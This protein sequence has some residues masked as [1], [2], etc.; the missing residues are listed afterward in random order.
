MFVL[1][2][3]ASAPVVPLG[4]D[5][6]QRVIGAERS[7]C[8]V[9]PVPHDQRA[10][11]LRGLVPEREILSPEDFLDGELR[12]RICNSDFQ[13]IPLYTI[14]RAANCRTAPP[15]Y[16]VFR[17]FRPTRILNYNHDCLAE[18]FCRPR[19]RVVTMHGSISSRFG[20]EE[21]AKL[22]ADRREFDSPSIDIPGLTFVEP[23]RDDVLTRLPTSL[24]LFDLIVLIGYS[25]ARVGDKFQDAVSFQLLASLLGRDPKAVVVVDPGQSFTAEALEDATKNARV[26]WLPFGWDHYARTIMRVVSLNLR[27]DDIGRE[28]FLTEKGA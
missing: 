15:S 28:L 8:A 25:F 21:F 22:I 10:L 7:G 5:L 24:R 14:A 19:H 23:E 1:G 12:D 27:L 3:G 26:Y 6:A 16:A 4:R 18:R 11:T 17:C 9:D 13:L 2:A 20:S